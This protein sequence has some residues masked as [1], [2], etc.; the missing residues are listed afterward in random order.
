MT[1]HFIFFIHTFKLKISA[2]VT[3]SKLLKTSV[4]STSQLRHVFNTLSAFLYPSTRVAGMLANNSTATESSTTDL[5]AGQAASRRGSTNATLIRM[6]EAT[7][8]PLVLCGLLQHEFGSP[9]SPMP[10]RR[11]SHAPPMASSHLRLEQS[12][13]TSVPSE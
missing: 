11:S 13:M 8:L 3:D 10:S 6:G 4:S 9:F 1:S 12:M 7:T 5:Q 2:L